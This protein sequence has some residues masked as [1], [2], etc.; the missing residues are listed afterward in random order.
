M[1]HT[2]QSLTSFVHIGTTVVMVGWK[3]L[4]IPEVVATMALTSEVIDPPK[5]LSQLEIAFP[6]SPVTYRTLTHVQD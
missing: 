6:Y 2:P 1:P 3:Y 5:S 4:R